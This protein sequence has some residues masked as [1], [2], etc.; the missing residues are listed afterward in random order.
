MEFRKLSTFLKEKTIKVDIDNGVEYKCG[1]IRLNGRGIFVRE[2]KTGA[3]IQKQWVM[4]RVKAGHVVYSTLFADKGAFAI[5]TPE[6]EDLVFSEKFVSF[7]I[8]DKNVLPEYLHVIF[9]TDY[10]SSQC[11]D[12]KTGMAAMSLSHSS[13]KKVLQLSVPI[14]D[15]EMQRSI[16]S[17]FQSFETQRANL[18]DEAEKLAAQANVMKEKFLLEKLNGVSATLLSQLG[19]YINRPIEV[20]PGS[21][22][23]QVTVKLHGNGMT[24]RKLED[25]GNIKSKQFTI[26]ENDLVY[27]KIDVKS[28]AIAFVPKDLDGGIVTSDFPVIQMP[29]LSQIDR[30]FLMMY[31]SSSL[32]A[33]LMENKSKGTTNRVRAKKSTFLDIDIPWGDSGFRATAVKEYDNLCQALIEM[34]EQT[35]TLKNDIPVLTS[36][37]LNRLLGIDAAE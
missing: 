37:Y 21:Q 31:F 15:V 9:Q 29:G 20:I 34:V 14:P 17:E 23:M 24:L 19:T 26:R 10:L 36:K 25:G 7:E 2:I 35:E 12:F 28:G 3:D 32:F 22:Y 5:A 4:H 18:D 13:K 1:G 11:N 33:D 30:Q 6:D 27:S 8:I 16:V